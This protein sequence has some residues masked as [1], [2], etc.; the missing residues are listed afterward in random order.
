MQCGAEC[1]NKGVE[2]YSATRPRL[3]AFLAPS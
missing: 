3:A 1:A 2:W